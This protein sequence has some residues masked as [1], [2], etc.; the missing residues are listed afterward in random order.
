MGSYVKLTYMRY[1]NTCS[2]ICSKPINLPIKKKREHLK[3]WVINRLSAIGTNGLMHVLIRNILRITI[4]PKIYVSRDY[5]RS[6]IAYKQSLV[7]GAPQ[8]LKR[9]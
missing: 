4:I 6:N 1:C 3:L 9:H 2:L 7:L 5:K 8:Y